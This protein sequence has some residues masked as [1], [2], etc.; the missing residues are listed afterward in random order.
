MTYHDMEETRT[1]SMVKYLRVDV[2]YA[3]LSCGTDSRGNRNDNILLETKWI[4]KR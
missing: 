3:V 2:N 4:Q 1:R